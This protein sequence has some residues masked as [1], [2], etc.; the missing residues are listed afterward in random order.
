[1]VYPLHRQGTQ[2]LNDLPGIATQAGDFPRPGRT[3]V[4]GDHRDA[5]WLFP[6][7]TS[8]PGD[9]PVILALWGAASDYSGRCS[10]LPPTKRKD[11]WQLGHK[12]A[13]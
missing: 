7:S 9:Q 6:S 5:R 8:W 11:T 3:A 12:Q 4:L 1:M 2:G 13:V 10:H